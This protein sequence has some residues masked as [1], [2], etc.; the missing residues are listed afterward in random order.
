MVPVE[1][2]GAGELHFILDT[3]AGTTLISPE[4]RERLDLDPA[5]VRLDSIIGASGTTILESVQLPALR[6]G[7][8]RLTEL[9][10]VV[11]DMTPFGEREGRPPL[12]GATYRALILL[13]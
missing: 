2:E 11:I 3:A 4:V 6:L 12:P 7:E 8:Q 13:A 5:A 10:V 1:I 9:R